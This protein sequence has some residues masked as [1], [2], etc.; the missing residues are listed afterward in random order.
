MPIKVLIVDDEKNIRLT[1]AQTLERSGYA[2]ET[3]ANGKEA[4]QKLQQQPFDVMVL[5]IKMPQMDGLEVLQQVHQQY[6]ALKILMVSAHAT[7]EEAVQAMKLGAVDFVQ[8]PLGYIPKPY[9]P[10]L[11]RNAVER[12]LHA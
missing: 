4:I 6:P 7:L 3:A 10:T 9:T 12:L 2:I 11:I 8:K 1:T 5:D